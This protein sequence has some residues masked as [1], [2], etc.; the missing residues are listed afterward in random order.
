MKKFFKAVFVIISLLCIAFTCFFVFAS[1]SGNTAILQKIERGLFVATVGAGVSPAQSGNGS[2]STVS[3]LTN[4]LGLT[5][6]QAGQVIALADQLGVDTDD[7][8][9][10]SRFIA[11]NAG[12]KDEIQY[13]AESY[14][15]GN[16][17]ESQAK[18]MLK[19]IVNL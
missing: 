5:T 9:E 13:I 12:N 8:A 14:Q 19:G 1:A 7:P 6:S 16:I 10:M 15:N 3:M 11:K 17:T 18:S 2:D 4:Q